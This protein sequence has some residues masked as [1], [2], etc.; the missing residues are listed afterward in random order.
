MN[1]HSLI[2]LSYNTLLHF[3]PLEFHCLQQTQKLALKQSNLFKWR[4]SKSTLQH[5]IRETPV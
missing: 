4:A 1:I 2:I 5:D 3:C